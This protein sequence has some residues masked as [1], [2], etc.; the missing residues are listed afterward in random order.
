M[1][2]E[3]GSTSTSDHCRSG[4]T[5][6]FIVTVGN[7]TVTAKNYKLVKEDIGT[8]TVVK[9]ESEA[10]QNPNG[11]G[12]S[13]NK[14]TLP[15]TSDTTLATLPFALAVVAGAVLCAAPVARRRS[16]F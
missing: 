10:S 15:K 5:G 13:K 4:F 2:I 7:S 8:L 14:G 1:N 6:T 12:E 3:G 9:D 11:N 16:K